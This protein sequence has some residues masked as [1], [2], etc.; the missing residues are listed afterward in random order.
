LAQFGIKGALE[1]LKRLTPKERDRVLGQVS[2]SDPKLASTLKSKIVVIQDLNKFTEIQWL[3]LMTDL[4]MEDIA[5]GLMGVGTEERVNIV[6][7]LPEITQKKLLML[8]EQQVIPL[9][10]LSEMRIKL[11]NQ[12][13]RILDSE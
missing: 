10:R 1:L 8:A 13:E 5:Y 11:L 6:K 3:D 12:I 4:S 7:I 2:Q 9:A